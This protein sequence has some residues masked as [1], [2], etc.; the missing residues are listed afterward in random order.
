MIFALSSS[1]PDAPID[2]KAVLAFAKGLT[3]LAK[4][5]SKDASHVVYTSRIGEI[6]DPGAVDIHVVPDWSGPEFAGIPA[7]D[8]AF[9]AFWG[10]R[11]VGYVSWAA[12]QVN[13]GTLY[14]PDGL[15]EAISHEGYEADVNPDTDAYVTN[16]LGQREPREVCDRLQG[17]AYEEEGSPGIWLAN[18]LGP[19][20]FV[21]GASRAAG[22][23]IASD[24]RAPTC[25]AAFP[26]TP[27]GYYAPEGAPPV[28][29][30]RVSATKRGQVE[31]TGARGSRSRGAQSR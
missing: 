22:L 13:G 9:H 6:G 25:T 16:P 3:R 28:F 27:G 19:E 5:W 26:L 23:D 30:E 20:A 15:W 14:G 18:A 29:G 12:V 17:T 11:P 1:C 4:W 10:G 31:R 8:V 21:L 2:S 7:T 24:L